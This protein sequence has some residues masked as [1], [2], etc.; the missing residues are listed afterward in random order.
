[1]A[2]TDCAFG[3]KFVCSSRTVSCFESAVFA[4][5]LLQESTRVDVLV[6]SPGC[7][8]RN[9]TVMSAVHMLWAVPTESHLA[10]FAFGFG[11]LFCARLLRKVE[12]ETCTEARSG[13]ILLTR[14][15]RHVVSIEEFRL[16]AA[17]RS[18]RGTSLG[19]AA[20]F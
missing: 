20:G 10:Y 13:G 4:S 19:K 9:N 6:L 15:S 7:R 8:L 5:V 18:R 14:R 2:N 1:M 17:K 16:A 11:A 12:R 3:V